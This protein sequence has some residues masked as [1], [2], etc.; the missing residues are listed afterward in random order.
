[1]LLRK[2]AD[3]FAFALSKQ[4]HDR[5]SMFPFKKMILFLYVHNMH[6]TKTMKMCNE[7]K[8]YHR[9]LTFRMEKDICWLVLGAAQINSEIWKWEAFRN[10]ATFAVKFFN[11]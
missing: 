3:F 10:T 8:I 6:P 2:F 4:K 11:Q 5:D 1:M 9:N 7:F